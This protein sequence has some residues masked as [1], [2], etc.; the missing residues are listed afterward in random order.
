[1][2]KT[3]PAF[4][5]LLLILAAAAGCAGQA[6]AGPGGA[7]TTG[8]ALMPDGTL[9]QLEVVNYT[10]PAGMAQGLSY[11]ESLCPQCG[12]LFV[13][14]EAGL[15]SFWMRDMRFPLDII[16]L[17]EEFAVVDVARN[18]EPCGGV[19]IPYQSR[20]DAKYVFEVNAG[21]AGEHAL[22]EGKRL[23]INYG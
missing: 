14:K 7:G 23:Q 21:F 10:N 12:M 18:M 19:C 20:H 6:E 1:M 5:P 9:V 17:D 15:R 4:L 8:T 16:F 2:M 11:R 22:E 3:A 13:F